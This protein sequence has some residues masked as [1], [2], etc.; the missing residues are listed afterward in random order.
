MGD[1][2]L[3]HLDKTS[4]S[5]DM[6]QAPAAGL[7]LLVSSLRSF[8]S[9]LHALLSVSELYAPIGQ[10][11]SLWKP[12][13]ETAAQDASSAGQPQDVAHASAQDG[14]ALATAVGIG[15]LSALETETRLGTQTAHSR[16]SNMHADTVQASTYPA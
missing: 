16:C 12:G 14:A 13:S 2:D 8:R 3:Q 1:P 11:R 5:L 6:L 15:V 4:R 7:V 10:Q 9:W